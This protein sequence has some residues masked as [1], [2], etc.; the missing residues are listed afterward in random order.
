MISRAFSSNSG[1]LLAMERRSRWGWI[2]ARAQTRATRLFQSLDSAELLRTNS[3]AS[4]SETPR[5]RRPVG[6][7]LYVGDKNFFLPQS[8]SRLLR[9]TPISARKWNASFAAVAMLASEQSITTHN[10]IRKQMVVHDTAYLTVAEARKVRK[11]PSLHL[12]SSAPWFL[13]SSDP[14]SAG[15]WDPGTVGP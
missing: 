9:P 5:D 2:P 14:G 15:P 12:G 11:R 6:P 1:S 4:A 3:R 13:V 7:D 10:R 8:W